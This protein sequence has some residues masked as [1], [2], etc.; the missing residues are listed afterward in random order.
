MWK[1]TQNMKTKRNETKF[2]LYK[3]MAFPHF[4]ALIMK[5]KKTYEDHSKNGYGS[6]K[7]SN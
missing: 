5:D 3:A 4:E 6:Q 1:Y 7:R 2:E